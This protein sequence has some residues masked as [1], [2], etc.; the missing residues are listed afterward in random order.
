MAKLEGMD[1]HFKC[2]YA[3]TCDFCTNRM[4]KTA[5]LENVFKIDYCVRA[6]EF[7]ARHMVY[8]TIGESEVPQD[9]MPYE[10]ERVKEILL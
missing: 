10:V 7:C 4:K 6:P 9:L 8:S 3:D 5:P 2:R 1:G